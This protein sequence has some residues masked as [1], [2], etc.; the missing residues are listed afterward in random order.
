V[1]Q[2]RLDLRLLIDRLGRFVPRRASRVALIAFFLGL[3][4]IAGLIAISAAMQ[5]GLALPMAYYFHRATSVAIPANLLLVPLLQLLMPAAVLAIGVSYIIFVVGK[6][7]SRHRRLRALSY[8]GDRALARR[9]AHRR[10]PRRHS[11]PSDDC[12]FGT[13]NSARVFIMRR[14]GWYSAASIALL[15]TSAT[16]VWVIKSQPRIR[17]GLVEMTTIDVG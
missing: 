2:F 15:I 13:R 14:R 10:H 17:P 7:P 5:L 16:C 11:Q 3:I 1:A 6:N 12:N 9:Y 8:C 4:G